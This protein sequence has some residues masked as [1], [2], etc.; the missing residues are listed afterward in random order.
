[1]TLVNLSPAH[2]HLLKASI[3]LARHAHGFIDEQRR[4]LSGA[5]K[6]LCNALR[7]EHEHFGHLRAASRDV[8]GDVTADMTVEQLA[9][10]WIDEIL[11]ENR[12]KQ[13]TV[14]HYADNLR[15]L[16]PPAVGDMPLQDAT[17]GVLDRYL[18]GR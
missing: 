9:D 8:S 4:L 11:L 13:Q 14:G 16:I 5:H 3:T 17:V 7:G 1:M 6:A 18:R 15:Y 10:A 12:V 2:I